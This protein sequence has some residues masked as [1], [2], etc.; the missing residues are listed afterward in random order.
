MPV[1]SAKLQ[2]SRVR[3]HHLV[4]GIA[5]I[6]LVISGALS[7]VAIGAVQ[8]LT[9]T[10]SNNEA[11]ARVNADLL[12]LSAQMGGVVAESEDHLERNEPL[13]FDAEAKREV[14][15]E[16]IDA[17]R[18]DL[19]ALIVDESVNVDLL[20]DRLQSATDDVLDGI[21]DLNASLVAGDPNDI[22]WKTQLL[23]NREEVFDFHVLTV[24][25]VAFEAENSNL[26]VAAD[27]AQRRLRQVQLAMVPAGLLVLVVVL[28]ANHIRRRED[29][30]LH[31]V[32]HQREEAQAIV[33][34]LPVEIAWKD[35]DHRLIGVNSQQRQQIESWEADEIVGRRVA[36]LAP[37]RGKATWQALEEL[38]QKAMDQVKVQREEYQL[39]SDDQAR[40]VRYSSAPLV[41]GRE[42]IGV[43]TYGEDVTEAREME[44]A[45]AT[46]GRMESIGQLA[47]GVAHEINTPVQF[48]SDNT[49]FLTTTFQE[50]IDVANAL[51]EVANSHDRDEVTRIL[52]QADLDFLVEEVPLALSQSREGLVRVAEIV[53][54]LKDFSHPGDEVGE[55]DLNRVIESTAAV[56]RNEWKYVADLELDLGDDLPPVQC[57]EGRLKQVILNL[58]VNAAHAIEDSHGDDKGCITVATRLIG[59]RVEISVGDDGAGMEAHV[60]ERIFDQF[61]TTKDVGRGTGQGLSLAWDVIQSH[62]GSI[63][64]ESAVGDG[65]TFTIRLP[66]K[67][68]EQGVPAEDTSVGAKQSATLDPV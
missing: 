46:S 37:D 35:T 28:V 65:T 17:L 25:D 58:I 66:L 18:A 19:D 45:L 27:L 12:Q 23:E 48:V 47:A 63:E 3:S 24:V 52:Q 5:G 57:S 49:E 34:C 40:T 15:T 1:E 54:A 55:T 2:R 8:S 21:E 53:R 4:L 42:Q 43:V 14:V 36:E 62:N 38:E 51:A 60:R 13:D 67:Q 7:W 31:E 29:R 22:S 33:D 10:N 11:W 44:R 41:L 6:F 9:W 50:L 59:D 30:L 61:F 64:V 20:V 26:A 32:N 39:W 16:I 68:T 56:S